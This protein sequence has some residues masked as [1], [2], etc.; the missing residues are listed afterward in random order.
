MQLSS[1]SVQQSLYTLHSLTCGLHFAPAEK[2][3]VSKCRAAVGRFLLWG[4]CWGRR[5]GLR[6]LG[7]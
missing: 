5:S 7:L 4:C 1:Q 6:S 2:P 3:V